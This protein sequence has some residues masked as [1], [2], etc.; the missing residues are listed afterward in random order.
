[1]REALLGKL[2]L[3][4]ARTTLEQL[5][6][7]YGFLTGL[8]LQPGAVEP[9]SEPGGTNRAFAASA[10][11][12]SGFVFRKK[13]SLWEV[14]FRGGEA[15]YLPDSLGAR[16][17]DYL[18]HHPNEAIRAFD[19]EV[20]VTPEKGAA[21][22]GTSIQ[23]GSDAQAMRDYR[24]A[25]GPLR[26]KRE[27]AQAAGDREEVERLDGEIRAFESALKSRGGAGD[28][29]ERARSNV[30]KAVEV[31]MAQLGKGGREEKAF[32]EHLESNLSAGLECLYSQPEGRI[33][34]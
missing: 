16:Y 4:L 29:G 5:A 34:V 7:V 2:L 6:A 33:W 30:R 13:G 15:F 14:I 22:S 10:R 1:M 24:E 25:L 32:A 3:L 28:T 11:A 9:L 20:A 31:V 8:G 27:E 21:R 26:E 17:L 12:G 19:L 18:L 23:P